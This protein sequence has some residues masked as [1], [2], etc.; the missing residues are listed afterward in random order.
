MSNIKNI[1]RNLTIHY[2]F[3]QGFFWIS[4][5]CILGFAALFLS[6]K[7]FNTGQIGIILSLSSVCAVL[8]QPSVASFA[9]KTTKISVKNITSI[10]IL[11]S[12]ILALL[13]MVLPYSF[14][15]TGILFILI[16]SIMYSLPPLLNSMALEY[17]NQGISINY[18]L[19]RG[20][21]SIS[22]AVIS[23]FLGNMINYN[24]PTV[25][26]PLFLFFAFALLTSSFTFRL[27]DRAKKTLI[28]SNYI[29]CQKDKEAIKT[30]LNL[31]SFF[32]KYKMFFLHLAGIILIFTTH[33]MLN[34]YLIQI[35]E[36]IGGNSTHL[37]ISLSIAAAVELPTM[38]MYVFI[39]RKYKCSTLLKVAAFFFTIKAIIL[40]FA[41]NV[42]MVYISQILQL[43]SYALFIPASVDYVNKL[44]TD[45]DKVKGQAFVGIA[46]MGASGVFGNLIA[47]QIINNAGVTSMVIT[48]AVISTFGCIILFISTKAST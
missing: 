35:L 32:I 42:F 9:D 4:F 15:L 22:F 21:G 24:G 29:I 20:I 7:Q 36:Q 23:F 3:I 48:S 44:M 19:A 14:Y 6:W 47:G 34:T 40:I 18:G 10:V 28:E 25:L 2:A 39:V 30:N 5:C 33:S 46:T 37:G 38:A 1:T 8:I 45:Q 31:F 17:M 16:T 12:L 13:L 41:T 43:L 11:T 26:L 27:S